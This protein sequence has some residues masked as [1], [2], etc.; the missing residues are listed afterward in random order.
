MP[1]IPKKLY[2]YRVANEYSFTE[3]M[4]NKVYYSDPRRLND[5]FDCSPV[6][7]VDSELNDLE[8]ICFQLMY[9]TYTKKN[10]NSELAEKS[11]LDEITEIRY[12]ASEY[13]DRQKDSE[14]KKEYIYALER[15]IIDNLIHTKGVLC[16]AQKW[17]C[18]LMWSHYADQHKGVCIEYDTSATKFGVPVK[19]IYSGERGIKTSDLYKWLI[20]NDKDALERVRNGYFYRKARQWKYEKEWRLVNK[21]NGLDE[22]PFS[23]SAIYFGLRCSPSIVSMVINSF[24]NVDVDPPKFYRLKEDRYTFK[25]IRR[26][27]PD[28]DE[29]LKPCKSEMLRREDLESL[30]SPIPE[31]E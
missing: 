7:L 28:Y 30:F 11:A 29:D 14:A 1:T 18:P 27:A 19:V 23:I 4:Q 5:P 12:R 20:N 10:Y 3:I 15:G 6:V 8:N 25:L 17:D 16:L 2:K 31:G 24:Q 9:L 26:S 13:G 21:K 22:S